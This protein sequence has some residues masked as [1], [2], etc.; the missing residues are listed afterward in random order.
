MDL[1]MTIAIMY[2]TN[3]FPKCTQPLLWLPTSIPT[4]LVIF[5]SKTLFI[6]LCKSYINFAFL[7]KIANYSFKN[8]LHPIMQ[9]LH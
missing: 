4:G 1:Y 5:P 9:K 6:R 2:K 3:L 7:A 8:P